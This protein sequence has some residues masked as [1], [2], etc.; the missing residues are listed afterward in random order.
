MSSV[1]EGVKDKASEISE[2]ASQQVEDMKHLYTQKR[3]ELQHKAHDQFIN[4]PHPVADAT[5]AAMETARTVKRYIEDTGSWMKSGVKCAC[6]VE[7]DA[8]LRFA[9]NFF[10]FA[11]MTSEAQDRLS[12]ASG[13]MTESSKEM[14]HAAKARTESLKAQIAP[15][16]EAAAKHSDQARK[17]E[18]E[19]RIHRAN[20]DQHWENLT[21]A[22]KLRH[23]VSQF[24]FG[25]GKEEEHH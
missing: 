19:R 20:K 17:E 15:N 1:V 2:K 4:G 13:L 8:E 23:R 7:C 3:A 16:E 12:S 24:L 11:D 14:K 6:L 9:H 5:Y 25:R 18:E 22:G 21:Y 10:P